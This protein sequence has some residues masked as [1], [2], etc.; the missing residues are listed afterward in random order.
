MKKKLL[1][2]IALFLF[3]PIN[4]KANKINSVDM[5]IYVDANGDAYVTEIWNANLTSGTEGYKPYYNLGKASITDFKVYLDGSEYTYSNFWNVNGSFNSKSFKN[6]INYIDN[7]LELCWGISKYGQNKYTLKYKINGFVSQTTD[8]QMIYW[9]LIPHNLSSKP[10]NV[11][12]KIY[13]DQKYSSDI[14]VWGYGNYGGTAYVY[15]GYI[16]MNSEGALNK[17]EYMTILVKF[18]LSTFNTSN[19][20]ND[21]F[22]YYHHLAEV[23]S[24]VYSDN[25]NSTFLNIIVPF[26]TFF[27][28]SIISI[29]LIRLITG[30]DKIYGSYYIKFKRNEKKLPKNVF[31][32]RDIPFNN[33]IYLTYWIATVYNLS[34]KKTDL[35]GAMLLKWLKE[36][37]IAI[38]KESKLGK[39]K[40]QSII[41]FTLPFS[42]NNSLEQT[43]Y[44]MM[45]T[46]SK[47]GLLKQKEFENWCNKNYDKI[48]S[49]FTDVLDFQTELFIDNKEILEEKALLHNVYTIQSSIYDE[50]IKLKGFKNFLLEFS[51]INDKEAIEVNM[52]EY[53]LIYAQILG[54]AEK[55]AKQ[56]KNL[57][58]ELLQ[59]L[60]YD[61]NDITFIYTISDRG[62]SAASTSKSRA[63]SYSSGGG[64]FS[65]GGGGGGSFGGGSGGGGFR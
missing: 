23:D 60:D 31:N 54:I 55:V 64:G 39:K 1:V 3:L 52:W 16:E 37:K 18:P 28:I 2:L 5:S 21:K 51:R 4:V 6:G 13:S 46:A 22:D 36:G 8:A 12:I 35:L 53:Y 29:I 10:N 63:S 24:I 20:L 40:A 62:M 17:N 14:P 19:I 25:D 49:W 65:S 15:D 42:T 32:Y 56:F 43:L 27:G 45:K 48:Y 61:Y 33:N 58:P 59:N 41:D 44:E 30:F 34:N 57:Y 9:T 7:G 47:D 38:K 11:H 50:A 26:L